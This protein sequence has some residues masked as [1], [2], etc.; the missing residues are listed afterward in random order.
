MRKAVKV[1]AAAAVLL[2]AAAGLL[3][4]LQRLAVP[5]YADGP[6]DGTMTAAYYNE[7]NRDYDV[8]FLGD[9]DVC[10]TFD[11][12]LLYRS[13]G[14]HSF[15]RGGTKQNVSQSLAMLEESLAQGSVKTAVYGVDAL[16]AAPLTPEENH[17][18]LDG[19]HFSKAKV[20]AAE[21][22]ADQGESPSEYLFPLKTYWYRLS[23]L[24]E[25]DREYMFS[26]PE[27]PAHS[28]YFLH[29]E[30]I[31][32]ETDGAAA[33]EPQ[34]LETESALPEN[35]GQTLQYLEEMADL[36]MEN[37]VRL[38]LVK[39]PCENPDWTSAW[40]EAVADLAERRGLDYVRPQEHAEETGLDWRWDTWDG[41]RHLNLS[42]ADKYTWWFGKYLTE[43]SHYAD[44][45]SDPELEEIW[46]EKT[47]RQSAEAEEQY[48][49]CGWPDY[50]PPV[51]VGAKDITIEQGDEVSYRDGVRASDG[52]DGELELIVDSSKAVVDEPGTYEIVYSCRDSAGNTASRTVT[53]TVTKPA[54]G[55]KTL[56]GAENAGQYTQAEFDEAIRLGQ[57]VLNSIV[58]DSMSLR[59]KALAI[60]NWLSWHLRYVGYSD[61]SSW[62]HGALEGFRLRRGDCFTYFSCG[63]VLLTLAGIPSVDLHRVGGT[64]RHY[65]Q[66]VDVGNGYYHFDACP[67]PAGY[68][69]YGF[70]F[71][72]AQA[73]AFT[74]KVAPVRKNYY[75]YDYASCP[76][77][78]N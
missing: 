44:R 41:G 60:Y 7:E 25:E 31:P 38:V 33:G 74:Q 47:D 9:S 26:A 62:V 11:P 50:D 40:D 56:A 42:G 69:N 32:P 73:R 59:D 8:L 37:G 70:L 15:I 71:T 67:H 36:C 58:N 52:E 18:V 21:G 23:S 30:S 24:T 45:R 12:S 34:I 27:S 65:W 66:L 48:N 29:C 51:I 46:R 35:S 2:L 1:F 16:A 6:A 10:S 76:V 14:L 22:T 53:L 68:Y 64:T 78:P 61:K 57:Q 4:V 19:M 39:S 28:G 13:Y 55:E 63:K 72:E 75:V 54:V 43:S 49:A 3:T 17:L 20:T 5:K 77:T